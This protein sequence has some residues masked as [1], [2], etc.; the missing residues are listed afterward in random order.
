MSKVPVGKRPGYIA[1]GK[2]NNAAYTYMSASL[3][4]G[5]TVF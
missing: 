1:T 4:A 2:R 3:A 5:G